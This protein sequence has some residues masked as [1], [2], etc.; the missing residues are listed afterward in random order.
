MEIRCNGITLPYASFDKDWQ[1]TQ[2]PVVE[3]KHL[4]AALAWAKAK[5]QRRLEEGKLGRITK[6]EKERIRAKIA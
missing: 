2:T 4:G 5:Q 3:N 6:R 1:E